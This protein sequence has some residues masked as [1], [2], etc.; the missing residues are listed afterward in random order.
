MR[1]Y[2]DSDKQIASAASPSALQYLAV[3]L[4]LLHSGGYFMQ[5]FTRK[6]GKVKALPQNEND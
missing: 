5:L 6:S 1:G 3:P 4:S 2:S